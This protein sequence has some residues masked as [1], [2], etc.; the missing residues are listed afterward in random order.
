MTKR[1]GVSR[2]AKKR[3]P[4]AR[5]LRTLTPKVKPSGKIYRRQ[6]AKPGPKKPII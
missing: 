6:R 2:A 4:V 3:N 1:I 5:A